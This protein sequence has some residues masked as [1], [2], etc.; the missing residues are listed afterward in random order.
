MI[1]PKLLVKQLV[2]SAPMELIAIVLVVVPVFNTIF[3]D[4][5]MV[6]PIKLAVAKSKALPPGL[7]PMTIVLKHKKELV[8]TNKKAAKMEVSSLAPAALS[9]I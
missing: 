5:A 7:V 1:R 4:T 9:R 6:L 3:S 8:I 2:A